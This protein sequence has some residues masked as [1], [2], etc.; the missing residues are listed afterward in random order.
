MKP[1]T[2]VAE[3]IPAEFQDIYIGKFHKKICEKNVALGLVVFNNWIW[4]YQESK[5]TKY[6]EFWRQKLKYNILGFLFALPKIKPPCCQVHILS[7]LHLDYTSSLSTNINYFCF[8][9]QRAECTVSCHLFC[10]EAVKYVAMQPIIT[11]I[12]E[13]FAVIHAGIQ[14]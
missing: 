3:H 5:T 10:K 14:W 6:L 8:A 9:L 4:Q 13:P 1:C 12:M 11:T 2:E 7:F